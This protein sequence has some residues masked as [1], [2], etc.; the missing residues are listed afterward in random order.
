MIHRRQIIY[1][2]NGFRSRQPYRGGGGA[3]GGGGGGGERGRGGDRDR[4]QRGQRGRG[5]QPQVALKRLEM[6]EKARQQERY[7]RKEEDFASLYSK[8]EDAKSELEGNNIPIPVDLA[9]QVTEVQAEVFATVQP[10][11]AG[12]A[13]TAEDYQRAID[14]NTILIQEGERVLAQLER[15]MKVGER[16]KKEVEEQIKVA[17]VWFNEEKAKVEKDE[18]SAPIP[19]K[20]NDLLTPENEA[21]LGKAVWAKVIRAQKDLE[22]AKK[23]FEIKAA[24]DKLK[25]AHQWLDAEIEKE[26]KPAQTLTKEEVEKLRSKFLKSILEDTNQVKQARD[27]IQAK[28]LARNDEVETENNRLDARWQDINEKIRLLDQERLK[29]E[30]ADG[31]AEA[32]KFAADLNQCQDYKT[33]EEKQGAWQLLKRQLGGVLNELPVITADPK[34]AK[35][36]HGSILKMNRWLDVEIPEA[37]AAAVLRISDKSL[38]ED[39]NGL[40]S[41]NTLGELLERIKQYKSLAKKKGIQEELPAAELD[42]DESVQEWLERF[43]SDSLDDAAAT[44]AYCHENQIKDKQG[45]DVLIEAHPVYKPVVE[46][47]KKAVDEFRKTLEDRI[48]KLV[49]AK[50]RER[51]KGAVTAEAVQAGKAKLAMFLPGAEKEEEKEEAARLDVNEIKKTEVWGAV[52]DVLLRSHTYFGREKTDQGALARESEEGAIREL[53]VKFGPDS[54]YHLTEEQSADLFYAAKKWLYDRAV[55]DVTG[56]AREA[57]PEVAREGG[58]KAEARPAPTPPSLKK[59]IGKVLLKAGAWMGLGV[60]AV[61]AAPTLGL[62][63]LA[64]V[65]IVGGLRTIDNIYH[66]AI[67]LRDLN[68]WK[69]K[70][71]QSGDFKDAFI[72]HLS[73]TVANLRENNLRQAGGPQN[74]QTYYDNA[75]RY[76]EQVNNDKEVREVPLSEAEIDKVAAAD[77]VFYATDDPIERERIGRELSRSPN[78]RR[79]WEYIDL[80]LGQAIRGGRLGK[81]WQVSSPSRRMMAGMAWTGASFG[82]LT[83]KAYEAI[84]ILRHVMR[85]YGG[86]KIGGAI[87]DWWKGK[88]SPENATERMLGQL[89]GELG[90]LEKT[91]LG[92]FGG[93][94]ERL[95]ACRASLNAISNPVEYARQKERFKKVFLPFL[96]EKVLK[97]E[98]EFELVGR[99]EIMA[100]GEEIRGEMGR[101]L[102]KA[103][104]AEMS[105]EQRIVRW[106]IAGRVIGAV[107]MV[108]LGIGVEEILRHWPKGPAGPG[109]EPGKPLPPPG[110][111]PQPPPPPTGEPV[112]PAPV[113]AGVETTV[114]P[115]AAAVVGRGEGVTH[116]LEGQ[117]KADPERWGFGGDINDDAAV[118]NW[119]RQM[120]E[121]FDYIKGGGMETRVRPE[122]Q[123]AYV[124]GGTAANPTIHEVLLTKDASGNFV[125]ADTG[126]GP[127][128]PGQQ[129]WYEYGHRKII[130]P[131]QEIT[132]AAPPEPAP[133]AEGPAEGPAVEAVSAPVPVPPAE[134]PAAPA[135]VKLEIPPDY[136]YADEAR[137]HEDVLK[138]R[139]EVIQL[140]EDTYAGD[141]SML[142]AAQQMEKQIHEEMTDFAGQVAGGESLE[143]YSPGLKEGETWD[144]HDRLFRNEAASKIWEQATTGGGAVSAAGAAEVAAA[145]AA[146][147]EVVSEGPA[148][149]MPEAVPGVAAHLEAPQEVIVGD[150]HIKI[151]TD[152]TVHTNP[153]ELRLIE[154]KYGRHLTAEDWFTKD[155]D[156]LG[157][158][159]V[160]LAGKILPLKMANLEVQLKALE[161]KLVSNPAAAD[162]LEKTVKGELKLLATSVDKPPAEIFSDKILKTYFRE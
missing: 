3:E 32:E 120:A 114:I 88:E 45:R 145:P 82:L 37:L 95:A 156:D 57:M 25:L 112:E 85:A 152:G 109:P 1:M 87:V 146:H 108:G 149:A 48:E 79:W 92:E 157:I 101:G 91:P 22:Q 105:K 148:A 78:D 103:R 44:L 74:F 98:S 153:A 154:Y 142:G 26:L 77:A 38:R 68:R 72:G 134:A 13:M 2:T 158:R 24:Q 58:V 43:V 56:E 135:A 130:L 116:A 39:E 65:G 67:Q 155:Y 159:H 62:S 47:L 144:E 150:V 83:S 122:D 64:A 123:V 23:K 40:K 129:E 124:L 121:R 89:E 131:E 35:E 162:I 84:P 29:K 52:V 4:D 138:H 100:K 70:A 17:I 6:A 54:D 106:R 55:T 139:L 97:E 11:V 118:H 75:H 41:I 53:I 9:N 127:R 63:A 115:A 42:T 80:S 147:P 12:E 27:F 21:L 161:E 33:L 8:L 81:G 143:G 160:D 20:I 132:G 141:A 99:E 71:Q 28:N 16:K 96:A 136:P 49:E 19:Q 86:W 5:E 151:D 93:Y 104:E 10:T 102:V 66:S 76:L 18:E 113:G 14:A 94:T 140:L 31:L 50:R 15:L 133:A 128:L 46:N 111:E 34:I 125:V 69:K 73:F 126:I 117:M 59:R 107:G 7:E 119:S 30:L 110:P 137:F 60:G 90:K 51:V 36:L 61:A